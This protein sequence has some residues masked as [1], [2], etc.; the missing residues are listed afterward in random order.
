MTFV[1]GVDR[2]LVE[3]IDVVDCGDTAVELGPAGQ[4]TH[5]DYGAS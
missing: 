2:D 3:R 1:L 4:I 5:E